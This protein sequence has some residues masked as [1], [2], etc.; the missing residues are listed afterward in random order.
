MVRR[1]LLTCCGESSGTPQPCQMRSVQ[2]QQV[3]SR[4]GTG[5]L[6]ALS[7]ENPEAL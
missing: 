4:E 7:S 1:L 2:P 6:G 5:D 3:P